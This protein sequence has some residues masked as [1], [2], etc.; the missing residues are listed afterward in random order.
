MKRGSHQPQPLSSGATSSRL[1][2]LLGTLVG[3]LWPLLAAC[4]DAPVRQE[5]ETLPTPGCRAP[6][7]VSDRPRSIDETLA[8]ANSLPKPLTLPCFVEALGRPLLLHAT[9][10][11]VSAQPAVGARSPRIF[12]YIEPLVMSV[13]VQGMNAQLLE[14]GEQRADFRSLKGELR[15]PIEESLPPSRPFEH[16]VFSEGLTGCAFCHAAETRE[17]AIQFTPAFVSQ[18]LRPFGRNRV[19]LAGLRE[20]RAAC[21]AAREPE[22]CA[23]LDALF[24]WG[25]TLEW[26]FPEGMA[27]FGG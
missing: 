26:E 17:P 22:R 11:Q 21:D 1:A 18:A 14:L 27:T 13:A 9:R 8:L 16:V 23:L 4:S 3:P 7:G 20:E 10:S 2:I 15:F 6:A 24:G 25:D 5:Q 19:P 12:V